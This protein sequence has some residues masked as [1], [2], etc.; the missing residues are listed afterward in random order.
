MS[1]TE[2]FAPFQP[3][4]PEPAK[5][6]VAPSKKGKKRAA[7]KKVANPVAE[8]P[9]AASRKR[10]DRPSTSKVKKPRK[11]R[12]VK[13]ELGAAMAALS[14]LTED[15]ARFVQDVV[16]AMQAFGKK[17]RARIVAALGKIFT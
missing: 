5:Q 11:P 1:D 9:A 14:G 6:E 7:P 3:Q 4:T 12:A 16:Q 10:E 13:I 2:A 17:Q 15:D 8:K